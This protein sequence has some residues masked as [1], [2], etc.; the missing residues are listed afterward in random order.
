MITLND[1]T[2]VEWDNFETQPKTSSAPKFAA[3]RGDGL[4]ETVS[5]KDRYFKL[6]LCGGGDWGGSTPNSQ[7]V[8]CFLN[9]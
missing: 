5:G 2:T 6:L 3:L 4:W 7:K 9:P 8:Q 1:G